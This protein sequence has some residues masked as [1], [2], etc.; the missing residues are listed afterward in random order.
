[1]SSTAAPQQDPIHDS[2]RGMAVGDVEAGFPEGRHASQVE[3]AG[4]QVSG[5]R[6]RRLEDRPR[7]AGQVVEVEASFT[8]IG[9]VIGCQ[10]A[11]G[12]V[13][14]RELVDGARVVR[15]QHVAD[16]HQL[17]DVAMIGDVDSEA[18]QGGRDP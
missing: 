18:G 16:E 10:E 1:M 8:F 15:H 11:D 14:Q 12:S 4:T 17:V 6:F 9:R 5:E 7:D 2:G 13:E 3:V